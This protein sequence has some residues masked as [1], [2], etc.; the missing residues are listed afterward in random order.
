MKKSD[1]IILF[2]FTILLIFFLGKILLPFSNYMFDFHDESQPTRVYEFVQNIKNMHIP[3]RLAPDYSFKLG[4]PVFNFYAP[5]SYWIT[6]IINL[7]G[8]DIADSLKLSFLLAFVIAFSGFF[9]FLR[10]F[11][12]LSASLVGAALYVSSPWIAVETFIR[13][14]LG[15][16]WFIAL[17]PWVLALVYKNSKSN[18]KVTFI[19]TTLIMSFV[20]TTHNIL[21]LIGSILLFIFILFFKN[22]F[23]NLAAFFL[24]FLISAYFLIPAFFELG[25]VRAQEIASGINFNDH[26]VCWKQL[27]S[28]PWD[29]GF[30]LPGCNDGLSFML[31]KMQIIFGAAGLLAFIGSYFYKKITKLKIGLYIFII[32][33]VSIF[34]TTYTSAPVWRILKPSLLQF[35]WRL[36][37]FGLF[38]LSFFAG[39]CFSLLKENKLNKILLILLT[40]FILFFNSKFFTK[41]QFTK[42][43]FYQRVL[44]PVYLYQRVAYKVSEYLPK[45]VNYSEWLKLEV[46]A[47]KGPNIDKT[48]GDNFVIYPLDKKPFKV[49]SN[50]EFYKE[51]Q[52]K[53]QKFLINVHYFPF[54]KILINNQKYNVVKTDSL[55][56]PIIEANSNNLNIKIFYA[57]TRIELIG[58]II[59]ILG[60]ASLVIIYFWRRGPTNSVASKVTINSD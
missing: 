53:S 17:F 43:V 8:F 50:Q 19:A 32:T 7:I 40:L 31:G 48:I 4:L 42:N 55:G 2:I 30:S 1:R 15:E 33:I 13:G 41:F 6:S 23:K 27:W 3:P 56:R 20:L 51:V 26:F 11:F 37:A 16:V 60:L 22:R 49:L 14:D 28:S 59:T 29:Y 45:T 39:Y 58:N 47:A 35:P 34:F 25:L 21:S 9:K 44:A 57:Q 54:W 52:T 24:A 38:G 10:L 36:L 5:F 46:K 18:S 12:T